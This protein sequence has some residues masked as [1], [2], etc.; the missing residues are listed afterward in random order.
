MMV[1]TSRSSQN[2]GLLKSQLKYVY[3]MN[4]LYIKF[5]NLQG[6]KNSITIYIGVYPG[7]YNNSDIS[8]LYL[9]S[10]FNFQ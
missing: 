2:F 10:L 8:T 5:V 3:N 6:N 4:L 9:S 1:V 7:M